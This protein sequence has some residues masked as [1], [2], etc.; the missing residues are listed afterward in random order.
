MH[1]DEKVKRIYESAALNN[2]D[3]DD[4]LARSLLDGGNIIVNDER[5]CLSM[6]GYLQKETKQHR[7]SVKAIM[8]RLN[9]KLG[10]PIN[11]NDIFHD[12]GG[13]YSAMAEEAERKYFDELRG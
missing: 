5:Y 13:H 9:D 1:F 8:N 6:F 7:K 11:L 12:P 2:I 4:F 3:M 10:N